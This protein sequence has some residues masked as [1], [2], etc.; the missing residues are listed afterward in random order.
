VCGAGHAVEGMISQ[1]AY[2][3]T[4]AVAQEMRIVASW[5][6]FWLILFLVARHAAFPKLSADGANRAVSLVHAAVG[7][8]LPVLAINFSKLEENVGSKSTGSQISALRVSLGYFLYDT[9]CCLAIE[10]FTTGIDPA[11]TFHHLATL[12]GLFVGVFQGVSG[13]ELLL[14]LLLMEVSNPCM[15]TRHLLREA[16]YGNTAIADANDIAFAVTFLVCRNLL[17]VPVVYWTV[18]S[19][20]TSIIVK[21]GGVGILFVSWFWTGKLISLIARKLG[22][23]R[24]N[25]KKSE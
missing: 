13:H 10:V 16:G 9:F 6:L 20:R 15:H 14:C 18:M 24:P 4:P 17:G 12:S 5:Y 8:I 25:I 23:G 3:I 21:M 7:I 2:L 1:A 19:H 22:K 11:T